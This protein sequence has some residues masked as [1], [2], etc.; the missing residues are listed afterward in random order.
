MRI[1]T[2]IFWILLGMSS[3][4]ALVGAFTVSRLHAAAVTGVTKEAQDVARVVSLLLT[5]GSGSLSASAQEIVAK[6]HQM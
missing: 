4:V 1:R 5:P 6:L 3:L 2:K